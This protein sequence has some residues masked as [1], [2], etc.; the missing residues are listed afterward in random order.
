MKGLVNFIYVPG[1]I[2]T[3]QVRFKQEVINPGW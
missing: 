2:Y 1:M 3:F